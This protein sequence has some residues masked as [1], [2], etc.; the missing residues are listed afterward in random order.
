MIVKCPFEQ[1]WI[2]H[3][4]VAVGIMA[5]VGTAGYFSVEKSSR[6]IFGAY[7]GAIAGVAYYAGREVR[8]FEKLHY[9]DW[10]GFFA[11]L[12]ACSAIFATCLLIA[13]AR[14]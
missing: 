13:R 7:A 1:H 12:I 8:D 11:P 6:F 4:V 9:I 3:I 10:A 14:G 5:I 2:C